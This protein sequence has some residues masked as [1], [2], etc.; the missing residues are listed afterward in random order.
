M[1]SNII[2]SKNAFKSGVAHYQIS[3]KNIW[4][5]DGIH[6]YL[7]PFKHDLEEIKGD[8]FRA[9]ASGKSASFKTKSKACWYIGNL[10]NKI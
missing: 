3:P 5:E 9:K 1:R 4:I 6:V 10:R 7:R 2:I 8:Y